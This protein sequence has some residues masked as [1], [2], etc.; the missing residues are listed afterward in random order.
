MKSQR[1]AV[2]ACIL[3]VLTMASMFSPP[4][5]VAEAQ[6]VEA[7]WEVVMAPVMLPTVKLPGF[8]SGGLVVYGV[9][10]P[11]GQM[12]WGACTQ[13]DFFK[14]HEGSWVP[15]TV[16]DGT[17]R[18]TVTLELVRFVCPAN[19]DDNNGCKRLLPGDRL[20]I[21]GCDADSIIGYWQTKFAFRD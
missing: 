1:I 20:E 13:G 19:L 15:I 21:T 2:A 3:W 12:S 16:D 4:A 6:K 5:N 17:S 11:T 18:H 10:S 14:L 8:P 9:Q 7:D